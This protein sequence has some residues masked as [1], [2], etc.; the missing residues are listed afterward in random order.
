[1]PPGK[2]ALDDCFLTDEER[3]THAE[4]IAALKAGVGPVVG[5][6]TVDL[7][8]S[9]DR[10]LAETIAAPRDVPAFDNAA[11]DGYAFRHADLPANGG[12]MPLTMRIAAGDPAHAPLPEGAA[13]RIFTGAMMPADAD[14]VV[15]QEDCTADPDDAWVEIPP[16]LKAGANRR[17][18]GEDMR[19]GDTLLSPGAALRPQE[20]AAIASTGQ[21]TVKVYKPVRVALFSTGD[22]IVR[23][24]VPLEPGQVYDA[25][26]FL[27]RQLAAS[28][29]AVV[30]DL[31]VLPDDAV[32]VREAL[33]AATA[34]HDVILTTG[35]AS[36]GDEDH[37]VKT[38]D[39]IGRLH[40]W[41]LA[42]KPGRPMSFGE[43]GDCRFLGLPGNPVAAF[44]CFLL[45]ARP[46]LRTMG[47]A[48][49]PEPVRYL[50]PAG[51][52][53]AKKKPGRREFL[54]GA[55]DRDADGN[56]AVRRFERDG[57][58]LITSLREADGLIEIA[59][60]TTSVAH[61]EPVSFLPFTGFG[62]QPRS[63]GRD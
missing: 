4:A 50:I 32:A 28:C 43:I 62:L 56:P 58:G 46:V 11:V 20:V 16:G 25:N 51:F 54:R 13:A 21:A 38:L 26:H 24:G 48:P 23:P 63:A 37:V 52:E 53:I 47:G 61:G 60:D 42:I 34:A 40:L 17:R 41:Q 31:G 36:R 59:E 9:G 18:A 8:E 49:W 22:E 19:A 30:T 45:Y 55:L 14:T 7:A 2:P 39:A 10:I 1:M 29:G 5:I 3:L 33:E 6:E 57:S 35:G 27:L 15:M 44:V 12:R